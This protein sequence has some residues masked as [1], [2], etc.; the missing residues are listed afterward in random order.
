[1]LNG[2]IIK[3][4]AKRWHIVNKDFIVVD[5]FGDNYKSLS[6]QSAQ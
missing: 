4:D 1:M 3:Y 2:V 6:R 5:L